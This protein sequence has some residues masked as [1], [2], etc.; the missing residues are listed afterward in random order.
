M[1]VKISVQI[2]LALII[3]SIIK[4]KGSNNNKIRVLKLVDRINL[5][6][7]DLRHERSSRSSDNVLCILYVYI[8]TLFY[9][10]ILYKNYF[11]N[12]M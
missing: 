10:N 12:V 5:S 1:T 8:R 6:F 4:N 7:I 11:F 9:Y 3:L 2:T